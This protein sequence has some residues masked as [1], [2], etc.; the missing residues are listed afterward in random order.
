M[1][2]SIERL[3]ALGFEMVDQTIYKTTNTRMKIKCIEHGIIWSST[4]GEAYRK[5]KYCE[6]CREL[7][8]SWKEIA[9]S[10]GYNILKEEGELVTF[11]CSEMHEP[12]TTKNHNIKFTECKTCSGKVIPLAAVLEKVESLGFKLTN[13]DEFE[14]TRSTGNFKCSKDHEWSCQIHNVYGEKSGCPH[15]STGS[16]EKRCR[17]ILETIYR[18]PFSRTRDIVKITLEDGTERKLELDMYNRE[19]KLALEYNGIQHYVEDPVYFHKHGGF[20]EQLERDRLKKKWCEDNGIRLIVVSYELST[21]VAIAEYITGQLGDGTDINWTDKQTE[22]NTMSDANIV[23]T[24]A[25]TSYW[26]EFAEEKGGK[27]VGR[28][29][30]GRRPTIV[31]ICVKGHKFMHQE[32]DFN[33]GRWCPDCSK[34]KPLSLDVVNDMLASANIQVISKF[35]GSAIPMILRCD[36]CE[37]EYES[38]WD[39]VKQREL[40]NGRCRNC[41][42]KHAWIDKN[43]EKLDNLDLLPAEP[44]LKDLR[45]VQKWICSAGHLHEVAWSTIKARKVGCKTC[46]KEKLGKFKEN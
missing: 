12:W 29:H 42:S 20:E 9:H 13:P 35:N 6:K 21:F 32:S 33:R 19:L 31:M 5:A 3:S 39:N 25:E 11:Q 28:S 22:Y 7:D 23:T 44:V 15:C 16:G 41:Q 45:D 46:K 40:K 18:K 8:G 4:V 38:I 24:D 37:S 34:T 26:T 43:K 30:N 2:R 27:Y 36:V 10:K 17:F 14:T 1:Q